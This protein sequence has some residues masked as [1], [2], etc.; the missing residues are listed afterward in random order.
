MHYLHSPPPS[1]PIAL[2]L[3]VPK[4][5]VRKQGEIIKGNIKPLAK[6]NKLHG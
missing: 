5:E 6:F 4:A 3:R 2:K 1:S